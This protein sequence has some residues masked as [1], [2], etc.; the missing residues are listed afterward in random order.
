[1]IMGDSWGTVSPATE[2]FQQE[3]NEHNCTPGFPGFQNIAV[4]GTTARQW[5]SPLFLPKVRKAA[6]EADHVWITLGGNDALAECP[7]CAAKGGT[8]EE[9]A[10]ELITKADGWI[11]TILDAIH[12]ANPK[13]QV[14][15][16]GR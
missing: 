1:M 7:P 5:A 13:A 11:S 10:A 14:V 15:G 4:G 16:F 8:A 6:A 12:E 2:H 9:C 3:L